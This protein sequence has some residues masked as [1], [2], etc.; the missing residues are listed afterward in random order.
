MEEQNQKVK[1]NMAQPISLD[2]FRDPHEQNYELRSASDAVLVELPGGVRA[3][4]VT[5][6][7][8]LREILGDSRVS[9]DSR[10][11]R[12]LADG[13]VPAGWPLL[14]VVT[15][16]SMATLDGTDHRRL[17]T[18]VSQAFTAR[19]VAELRPK[20]EQAVSALL[21][22]LE[23]AL[24][25]ERHLWVDLR[26]VFAH[27]LPMTVI[28][29]LMGFPEEGRD[30]LRAI[31]DVLSSSISSTSEQI[32]NE[33]ALYELLARFIADCRKAPG[34]NLTG[35]LIRAS[36]D[37]GD[38]L[39]DAELLG[40][41]ATLLVAGHGTTAHLIVNAAKALLANPAQRD[42]VMSGAQ[43]WENVVEESLRYDS[44]LGQFPMRFATE[45]IEINGAVIPKGD[46]ILASY[47]AAGRDDKQFGPTADVFDITRGPTQHLS[48]GH[49]I[50][51]CLGA[52]LARM[53]T[54][55]AL[56]SL[57]TR[58]PDLIAAVDLEK[59]RPLPSVISNSVRRLPV[60]LAA[61]RQGE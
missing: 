27:P 6:Y 28:C 26:K 17:R 23:K 42:L 36:S 53:E 40:T 55:I 61:R 19:R 4:A 29:D 30:E 31:S 39:S 38:K 41:L 46:A 52:P 51:Y 13:E 35:D 5:H 47:A 54:S 60:R 49:G 25:S 43:S 18:L 34:A 20:I 16:R 56:S 2:I 3:W 32:S 24:A 59:L 21:D 48:F 8:T 37:G 15:V 57:F 11:W 33:K 50:H 9:R 10:H 7:A 44:P 1:T 12:A 58:F 45:D 14:S 22:D